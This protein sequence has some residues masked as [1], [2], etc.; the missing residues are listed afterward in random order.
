MRNFK[1]KKL[2]NETVSIAIAKKNSL[3]SI[4]NGTQNPTNARQNMNK[5]VGI[6]KKKIKPAETT[7][8]HSSISFMHAIYGHFRVI[9]ARLAG[10]KHH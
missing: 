1:I 5:L 2:I 4:E 7:T 8:T 3:I 9:E 6:T 10:D